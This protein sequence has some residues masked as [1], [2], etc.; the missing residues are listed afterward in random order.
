MAG[1]VGLPDASAGGTEFGSQVSGAEATLMKTDILVRYAARR[2]GTSSLMPTWQL[3]LV[4]ILGLPISPGLGLIPFVFG[5][6]I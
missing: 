6:G 5:P 1:E 4:P 2:S 3:I